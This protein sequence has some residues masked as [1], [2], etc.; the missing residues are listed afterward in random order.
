MKCALED[1][2]KQLKNIKRKGIMTL[3]GKKT[4]CTWY[5]KVVIT[6]I[7]TLLKFSQLIKYEQKPTL[8]LT[9]CQYQQHSHIRA[10]VHSECFID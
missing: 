8:T 1:Q 5:D 10:Y 3:I 7:T 2:L 6:A 4:K 9:R